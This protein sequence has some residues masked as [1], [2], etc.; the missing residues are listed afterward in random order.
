MDSDSGNN[1]I[2]QFDYTFGE[3]STQADVYEGCEVEKMVD[4]AIE[5]YHGTIFA[6][7]QTGSGK[8]FTMQGVE[9]ESAESGKLDG[10]IPRVVQQLFAKAKMQSGSRTFTI[11]VS[12]LQIYNEKIFDLLNPSSLN[13]RTI[14]N[15]IGGLRLRW[16]KN[17]QF[18]V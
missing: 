12:F 15:N 14:N 16:N 3:G 6:Y 9:D 8:T 13:P 4:R 17:E 11:S 5:G 18:S 10:I 2:F 1:K 7:G